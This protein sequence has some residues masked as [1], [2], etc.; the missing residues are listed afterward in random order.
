MRCWEAQMQNRLKIL[1]H[2][3]LARGLPISYVRLLTREL[4]EH[5][6][7]ALA[8]ELAAGLPLVEAQARAN[9]RIGGAEELAQVVVEQ[10]QQRTF[11]GRHPVVSLLALTV[12]GLPLL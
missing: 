2:R 10:F 4:Q 11:L 6:E 9:R 5:L 12:G 7:D 3:L 8:E 1:E